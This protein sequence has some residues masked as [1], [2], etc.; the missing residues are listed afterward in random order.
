MI[1]KHCEIV[2]RH[3]EMVVI[4]IQNKGNVPQ[5]KQLSIDNSEQ[6]DRQET[7]GNGQVAL[8][9]GCETL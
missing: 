6:A 9:N 8:Q 1:M 7:L 4:C 3:H 2:V 5:I